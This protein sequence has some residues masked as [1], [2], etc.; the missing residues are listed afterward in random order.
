VAAAKQAADAGAAAAQAPAAAG[1]AA[2]GASVA[3]A[4]I[5]A[6]FVTWLAQLREQHRR[7]LAGRLG[8]HGG[9][10]DDVAEVLRTEMLLEQ[11]F[12]RRSADRLAGALPQALRI[13]DPEE[14][15]RK[16]RQLL[17]D[18]ERYARQR[19]EAMVARAIAA[20]SRAAVRR[21]SPAG[22]FWRLGHA[23]Q[24]T[25][26]CKFMADRFWP[27]AVLDRVHPPRHYGCTSSLHS[28]TEAIVKGWM[29]PSDVPDTRAAVRAASGVVMEAEEADALLAELDVRDRLLEQGVDTSA[30]A[31][32]GLQERTVVAE[33]RDP[34]GRW[35]RSAAALLKAGKPAEIEP[36]DAPALID[37]L[38]HGTRASSLHQLQIKGHPNLFR[39]HARELSRGEMPQIPK[40]H[41]PGF[42]DFL[43]AK[44]ITGKVGSVH[45]SSLQ[46]TQNQINGGAAA[47]IAKYGNTR[48]MTMVSREGHVLDGHHRWGA[49][50]LLGVTDPKARMDVLRFSGGTDRILKLMREYN[51]LVGITARAF[52]EGTV[53]K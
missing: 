23:Q 8:Q 2:G 29:R 43:A 39:A 31:F 21:E 37:E 34:R 7:W 30:I 24:H 6:G 3:A 32:A 42:M 25:E 33:P 26:G 16:I 4:A 17:A 12:A 48:G 18:E 53:V 19:A 22:A 14:R 44:G 50:A 1:L 9:Q 47:E 46:A 20:V 36:R 5:M 52:G 27:W 13:S 10:A 51:E 15:E 45:P 28:Y 35:V 41:L 11:E 40:E 38:T 49:A